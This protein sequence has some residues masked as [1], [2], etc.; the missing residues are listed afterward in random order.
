MEDADK[1]D[2]TAAFQWRLGPDD[3]RNPLPGSGLADGWNEL[4]RNLRDDLGL[5]DDEL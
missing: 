5:S 3:V 4:R 1:L 2:S